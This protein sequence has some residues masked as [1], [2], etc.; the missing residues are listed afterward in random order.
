MALK[1]LGDGSCSQRR[2][3]APSLHQHEE[4]LPHHAHSVSVM[5]HPPG[6]Q[7]LICKSDSLWSILDPLNKLFPNT[8][9]WTLIFSDVWTL[10]WSTLSV[11]FLPFHGLCEG[12]MGASVVVPPCVVFMSTQP[13][14]CVPICD[15]THTR[16][17]ACVLS[18][19]PSPVP[20]CIVG[21]VFLRFSCPQTSEWVYP[22]MDTRERLE[23][24]RKYLLGGAPSSFAS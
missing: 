6:A 23:D 21:V 5:P 15:N 3:N 20:L 7:E 22:L 1:F 17:M 2:Q 13:R 16:R 11:S 14:L 4:S 18:P 24:G 19:R 9:P 12:W 10:V 8:C